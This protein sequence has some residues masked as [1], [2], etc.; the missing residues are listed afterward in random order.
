VLKE[1]IIL[2]SLELLGGDLWLQKDGKVSICPSFIS[3]F[4]K[5]SKSLT[6]V[7]I[8]LSGKFK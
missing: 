5:L 3:K 1:I 4:L 6:T 2:G 7:L 8:F